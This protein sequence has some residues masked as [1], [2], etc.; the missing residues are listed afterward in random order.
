MLPLILNFLR[1]EDVTR[2]NGWARKFIAVKTYLDE[3][4]TARLQGE[5]GYEDPQICALLQ[6]A[7]ILADAHAA[8]HQFKSEDTRWSTRLFGSKQT[9]NRLPTDPSHSLRPAPNQ[10]RSRYTKKRF[11]YAPFPL[12]NQNPFHGI[13]DGG[14]AETRAYQASEESFFEHALA[15]TQPSMNRFEIDNR[16]YEDLIQAG[17]AKTL[18]EMPANFHDDVSFPNQTDTASAA[19]PLPAP[20]V[21]YYSSRGWQRA[22]LQQ[23]L[24]MFTSHE[25]RVINT[26]WRRVVLPL[27]DSRKTSKDIVFHSRALPPEKVPE[28]LKDPFPWVYWTK[29]YSELRDVLADWQRRRYNI[30]NWEN[31]SISALPMNYRGPYVYNGLSVYDDYWLKMGA[32][33]RRLHKLLIDSYG[34]TPR[35]FLLTIL[36]DIEA[37]I[38]SNPGQQPIGKYSRRDIMPRSEVDVTGYDGTDHPPSIM[39]ID[40]V[41]AAWLRFLCQPSRSSAMCD[42]KQKPTKNLLILFNNRLQSFFNNTAVSGSVGLAGQKASEFDSSV[43]QTTRNQNLPLFKDALAYINGGPGAESCHANETYQFSEQ[44]AKDNLNILRRKGLVR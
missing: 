23:C 20:V 39:L 21:D 2:V 32:Y 17:M 10:D 14:T 24:N 28:R 22:G 1:D 43:W 12:T 27:K 13:S 42:P 33:L 15:G 5:L 37:G 8:F 3:A 6:E 7:L 38:D 26:P 40:E 11:D 29:Q 9:S 16:Q 34:R 4:N 18:A 35:H 36:R 41:D 44:E 30:E 31:F 25:N 19:A